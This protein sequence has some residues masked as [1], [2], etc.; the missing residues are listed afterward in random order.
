MTIATGTRFDRYEI[1]SLLG[2]GGMGEV[3]SGHRSVI[4]ARLKLSG[5][6][7]KEETAES[8]LALRTLRAK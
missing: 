1:L 6:W 3:E 7:W 4:Q 2:Q 8:M 5:A